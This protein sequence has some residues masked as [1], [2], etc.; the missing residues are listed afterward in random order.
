MEGGGAYNEHAGPLVGGGVFALPH[1]ERA[2]QSMPLD[3]GT[4]QPV[5]IV[6]YGSSQGKNSL[7]PMRLAIDALQARLGPDQAMIIG[8]F[9]QFVG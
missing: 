5:V 7:A 2:V 1:L 6:D 9:E 8:S 4:K 3:A